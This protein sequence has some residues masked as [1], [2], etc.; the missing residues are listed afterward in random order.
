[1]DHSV[2]A[3]NIFSRYAQEYSNKYMDQ[4]AYAD[5]LSQFI[6]L[7]PTDQRSV[8]DIGCGPGNVIR[9]I[10]QT[11]VSMKVTG[12]DFSKEMIR[13]ANENCPGADLQVM[14]CRDVSSV[15]GK[16]GGIVCSF[17]IPYLTTD[18]TSK[19]VSDIS[20]K[21]VDGGAFY[22]SGL[23]GDPE[24]SGIERNSDGEEVY[25]YYHNLDELKG[26]LKDKGFNLVA[27]KVIDRSRVQRPNELVMVLLKNA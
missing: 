2:L 23:L 26:K 17:C 16:F 25:V 7:I 4:S 9:H 15:D 27:E 6:E 5:E 8:L 12:I 14:D 21:I 24:D 20:K 19:L 1:M 22:L 18:E 3:H 13:V 10:I 11:D